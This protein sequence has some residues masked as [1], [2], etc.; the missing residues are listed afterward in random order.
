MPVAAQDFPEVY[1]VGGVTAD[2]RLNIRA[3]PNGDARIVGSYAPDRRRIEVLQT[4]PDGKWG[5]VGISEGNG[6]VA[7]RFLTPG[8]FGAPNAEPRPMFCYGTEPFWDLAM[9]DSGD[10]YGQPGVDRRRLEMTQGAAARG[11]Y[12]VRFASDLTLIVR[13]GRC[14]DGMS[15]R[16]FGLQ[17]TLFS[18]DP[19]GNSLQ[20]G[21]CT[22][23]PGQ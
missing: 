4:T 6:W 15:D 21:C 5:K 19:M 18:I 12:L 14:N 22:F 7:M 2:D 17:A 9:T 8:D 13:R 23:D 11:G 20:S 3:M 1:D 16:E 10:S